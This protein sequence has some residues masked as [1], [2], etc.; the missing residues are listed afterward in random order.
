M[1]KRT[2][3]A[4]MS[5]IALLLAAP[6][7]LTQADEN[8]IRVKSDTLVIEETKGEIRFTGNVTVTFESALMTCGTLIVLATSDQPLTVKKGI[9][10]DG[11]TVVR[12]TER[13]EAGR[14]EFDLA[15]GKVVL[16]ESPRLYREKD[17]ITA[18]RIVYDIDR[19]QATFD[20]PVEAVITSDEEIPDAIGR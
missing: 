2:T 10:L 12:G 11:V 6:P 17:R 18:T 15:S 5:L 4:V 19:G 13:A 9:A 7:G 14:A 8:Q 20:G 16:T 1:A 3:L